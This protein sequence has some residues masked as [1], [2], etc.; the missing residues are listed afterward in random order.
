VSNA[1]VDRAKIVEMEN[2]R[3]AREERL[4]GRDVAILVCVAFMRRG[5]IVT[6]TIGAVTCVAR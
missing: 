3:E 4:D 2:K 5:S 1:E 6:T